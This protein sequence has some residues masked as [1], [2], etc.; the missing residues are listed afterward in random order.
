LLLFFL[1]IFAPDFRASLRAI[2]TACFL[3]VT[4]LPLPDLSVPSF[5]S[6][7]T[8]WTFARPFDEDEVDVFFLV[9]NGFSWVMN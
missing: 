5:F 8:L 3:L 2:A 9:A 1:G 4:F 7:I 6:F